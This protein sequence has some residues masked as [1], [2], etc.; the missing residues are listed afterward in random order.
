M[1]CL[2]VV[3]DSRGLALNLSHDS[4]AFCFRKVDQAFMLEA[5]GPGLVT[6][7]HVSSGSFL[8]A[9]AD[10]QSQDTALAASDQPAVLSLHADPDKSEYN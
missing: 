2:L 9:R 1:G 8:G 5:V 10:P 6:L 3:R 4:G 7:R